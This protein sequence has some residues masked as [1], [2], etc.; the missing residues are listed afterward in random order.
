M[1]ETAQQETIQLL[2]QIWQRNQMQV[3]DRIAVLEQAAKAAAED[4]LNA[5]LRADATSIAHK[6][7]GSLGMFGFK[8]GTRLAREIECAFGTHSEKNYNLTALIE[9]L[10]QSVF[11]SRLP[12]A[13]AEM[14]THDGATLGQQLPS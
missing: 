1:Q 10:R 8:E 4:A 13:P 3:R 5:S 6:L 12:N 11:P 14:Q 9:E 7:A 2:A